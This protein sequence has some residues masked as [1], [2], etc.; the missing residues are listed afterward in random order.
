MCLRR[1]T[2]LSEEEGHAVTDQRDV[3]TG[4]DNGLAARIAEAA[5]PTGADV[6]ARDDVAIVGMVCELPG[7]AHDPQT[8]WRN[9]VEEHD[10]V[11]E[12]A[13]SRPWLLDE[14]EC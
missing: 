9:L 11:T 13:T 6:E 4:V 8:F 14:F 12:I 2:K 1:E 7:S 3:S 5:D 10:A